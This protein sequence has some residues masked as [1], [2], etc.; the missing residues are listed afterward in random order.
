MCRES[1]DPT[2]RNQYYSMW[3]DFLMFYIWPSDRPTYIYNNFS[4]HKYSKSKTF[5]PLGEI[6]P[7]D[8]TTEKENTLSL[9]LSINKSS[10]AWPYQPPSFL[11]ILLLLKLCVK[12][13]RS[14]SS[15]LSSEF[16]L[17]NPRSA[18]S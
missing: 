12:Q 14:V 5:S 9:D 2:I 10:S 18:I 15:S 1:R 4:L 16:P 13:R 11:A 7:I 3:R 8:L 17:S 6:Q